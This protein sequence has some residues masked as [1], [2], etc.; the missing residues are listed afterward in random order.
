MLFVCSQNRL[1]S[2]T[3]EAI[4]ADED[5]LEVSSAG[6]STDAECPVDAELIAW[7]D[8]VFAMEQ[9]HK[10]KLVTRFGKELLGKRLVVLQIPDNYEYMAPE[11]VELLQ[12]KMAAYLV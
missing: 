12:K 4:F 9:H 6:T 3:A 5:G 11:L 7:A 2:P 1:R 10:V 8:E